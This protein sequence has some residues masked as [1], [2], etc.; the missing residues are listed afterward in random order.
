L[1]LA[2]QDD[3]LRE[4]DGESRPEPPHGSSRL[5]PMGAFLHDWGIWPLDL[6]TVC[7]FTTGV[8]LAA[9]LR[10]WRDV[11]TLVAS[12]AVLASLLKWIGGAF[13]SSAFADAI[14]ASPFAP[15]GDFQFP[16]RPT[17]A[18]VG[19]LFLSALAIV[20]WKKLMR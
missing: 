7:A 12:A 9:G 11:A 2:P 14:L 18:V 13:G 17:A 6:Y 15:N 10:S 5:R 3:G 19:A 4:Q 8:L 20:V 1:A 16:V